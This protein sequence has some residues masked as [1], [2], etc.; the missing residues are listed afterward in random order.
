MTNQWQT[1]RERGN[2]FALQFLTWVALHLGR[3]AIFF[4]L[5]FVVSH[6]F[7]VATKAR[8]ASQEF[9]TRALQRAPSWWEIYCHLLTFAIVSVDRIY[10]LSGREKIFD[11]RVYGNEIFD[12]YKDR[13]CFLLTTHMGSFDVVRVMGMEIRSKALPVKIVLDV[14]HNANILQLL[15]SLDPELASG[16][17]DAR[18]PA[19]ALALMLSEAIASG[20]LVGIMADRCTKGDRIAPLDFFGEPA[21]F[22]QGAWHLAS[23]LQ[24]PV[25][26]CF[27]IYKGGNRYDLY[28]ELISDQLGSSRKDRAEAIATGMQLYADRVQELA[29]QNPFNWFNFYDFWHD[30]TTKH[31]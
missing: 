28:F 22:P 8:K 16:V 19:P 17:I 12:H 31:H 4:I 5:C 7:V 23:I 30:E 26:I 11:V 1:Q 27:G 6:Y 21:Y 18:T 15:Q 3:R 13:G 14:Q 25:I 29:R 2:R 20:K 24:A 10:F 9:L